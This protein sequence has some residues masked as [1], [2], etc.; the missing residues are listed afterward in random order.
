MEIFR[1]MIGYIIGQIIITIA[2]IVLR[3]KKD[4]GDE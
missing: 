3:D 1:F 4:K 2:F